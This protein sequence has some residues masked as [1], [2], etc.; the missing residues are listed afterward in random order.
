MLKKGLLAF[1]LMFLFS[2]AAL[3]ETVRPYIGFKGAI[4]FVEADFDLGYYN[5][6]YYHH[7]HRYYEE[8]RY[9]DESNDAVFAGSAALGVKVTKYIRFEFEYTHRTEAKQRYRWFPNIEQTFDSYMANA[10]FDFEV[11]QNFVPYIGLG[12]G[13]T[14]VKNKIFYSDVKEELAD[15]RFSAGMDLGMSFVLQRHLNL[16]FGFR[17]IYLG[18][19][20]IDYED[21][22]MYAMDLYCGIRYTI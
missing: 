1:S 3:S 19:M 14:Y 16:D 11:N 8:Y 6:Y 4:S 15:N 10:I 18:G 20:D 13:M 17:I 22:Y 21:Y 7:G 12:L 9:Y 5:D 2:A